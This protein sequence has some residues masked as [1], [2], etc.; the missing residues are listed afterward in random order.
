MFFEWGRAVAVSALRFCESL[1]DLRLLLGSA[2]PLRH[3]LKSLSH[4]FAQ[5]LRAATMRKHEAARR[6]WK[7]SDLPEWLNEKVY[8]EKI[9]PKLAT[10]TIRSI[11]EALQVSKPYA[12]DIRSGKRVPH[13]RH[14]ETLAKL[15]DITISDLCYKIPGVPFKPGT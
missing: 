15:V 12:A 1:N 11:M 6:A 8:R 3:L 9:Q 5:G 2:V 14:W 4:E 7:P 10:V 13:P